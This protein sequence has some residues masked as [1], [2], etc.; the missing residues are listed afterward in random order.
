MSNKTQ[1]NTI[2]LDKNEHRIYLRAYKKYL[3]QK[4][5]VEKNQNNLDYILNRYWWEAYFERQKVLKNKLHRLNMALFDRL[6][7][8]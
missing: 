7:R 5:I 3:K 2:K 4:L 1:L 6:L 8:G